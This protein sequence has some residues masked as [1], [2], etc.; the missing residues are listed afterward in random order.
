MTTCQNCGNPCC[1]CSCPGCNC[2]IENFNGIQCCSMC[3]T[4]LQRV[5]NTTQ[6]VQQA[7]GVSQS[8]YMDQILQQRL[9]YE[10]MNRFN[11]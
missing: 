2:R 1:N 7:Q 8:V 11:K 9:Q 10:Q 6:Q 4:G 5:H 3:I